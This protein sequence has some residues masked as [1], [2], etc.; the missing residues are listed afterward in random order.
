MSPEAG[1][2]GVG[3]E[4]SMAV[5][6]ESAN[7]VGEVELSPS[8][9]GGVR[10]GRKDEPMMERR[11]SWCCNE[12]RLGTDVYGLRSLMYNSP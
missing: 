10:A 9:V 4:P 11:L 3:V 6:D 8:V 5:G 1:V 12:V 7:G 2:A